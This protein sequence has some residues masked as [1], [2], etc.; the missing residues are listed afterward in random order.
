MFDLSKAARTDYLTI[1]RLTDEQA[2]DFAVSCGFAPNPGASAKEIASAVVC[3]HYAAAAR[4]GI[5][6]LP[7][8]TEDRQAWLKKNVE[9]ERWTEDSLDWIRR[10]ILI[11]EGP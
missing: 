9:D 7:H 2:H 4:L 10:S 1:S 8:V 6:S 11:L 5:C 3:D